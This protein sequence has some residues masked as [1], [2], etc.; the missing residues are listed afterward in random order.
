METFTPSSDFANATVSSK[1]QRYNSITAGRGRLC[2]KR[3]FTVPGRGALAMTTSARSLV[4]DA[5]ISALVGE[6]ASDPP[7]F[8]PESSIDAHAANFGFPDARMIAHRHFYN[9]VPMQRTFQD[10]LDGPSV[11]SLFER[12]RTQHFGARRPE[13]AEGADPLSESLGNQECREAVAERRVPR[14]RPFR[15]R[16]GE[17]RAKRDVR[18]SFGDGG[19]Q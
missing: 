16:S 13:R 9:A 3:V 1:R 12:E 15:A 8:R 18:A 10:Y 6:G 17:S 5:V 2:A 11:S 14:K 7:A 4:L 19:E